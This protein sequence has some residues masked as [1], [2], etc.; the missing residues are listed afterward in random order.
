[1][2]KI[3]ASVLTAAMMFSMGTAALATTIDG[4]IG[5]QTD[6]GTGR[7][8]ISVT[9]IDTPSNPYKV[10]L[11][12]GDKVLVTATP[13]A[14][15]EE[16]CDPDETDPDDVCSLFGEAEVACRIVLEDGES[17]HWNYEYVAENMTIDNIPTKVAV[18]A[19]DTA[20]EYL[21]TEDENITAETWREA[22]QDADIFY[23]EDIVIL[24]KTYNVTNDGTESPAETFSFSKFIC[25]NVKDAG[26]YEVGKVVDISYV[27]ANLLPTIGTVEYEVGEAG[28]ENATKKVYIDLPDYT[29]V[30]IYEYTCTEIDNNVAGVTYRKEVIKL[31]VTVIE[32]NGKIR[33]AA[34]HTEGAGEAKDDNFDN[35]YSAGTL[36]VSKTVTGILGDKEKYFDVTVTFTAPQ[37]K[38]VMS[39]I[40][41]DAGTD[42]KYT[43]NS[44]V[45]V[46]AGDGWTWPDVKTVNISV[47]DG[48][49]ITFTN[50]PYGVT[51]TVKEDDYRNN[52]DDYD[53]VTYSGTD[54]DNSV[55][56]AKNTDDGV[57]GCI[58]VTT[59]NDTVAITNTKGGNV[60]TG[61]S[62]DSIPYIAILGAVALGGT[63]FVVSKK[64]RSED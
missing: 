48:D 57:N 51:Y 60:D 24:E 30:G 28:S 7:D 42:G 59:F 47:S 31:V 33:V 41:Y 23:D 15:S 16:G 55:V 39:D 46:E 13:K 49:K 58:D 43:G 12:S 14:C 3:F 2:K 17:S 19:N 29:A 56:E 4:T 22:L 20:V 53:S 8:Y 40:Y 25:T 27:N 5:I 61:I 64:R 36:A 35:E 44:V 34:V 6:E 52:G 62:V 10:V 1:M 9:I 63:G 38:T 50:I 32:Q 26:E 45:A 11:Y 18:V 54:F 37:G 21:F